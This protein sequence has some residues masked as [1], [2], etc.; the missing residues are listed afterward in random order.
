MGSVYHLSSKSATETEKSGWIGESSLPGP[1]W[2][3]ALTSS[4]SEDFKEGEVKQQLLITPTRSTSKEVSS[5]AG[6]LFL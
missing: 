3:E 1:S 6:N 4:D 2:M 5:I